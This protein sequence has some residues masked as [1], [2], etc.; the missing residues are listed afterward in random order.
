M[1]C[2]NRGVGVV[3]GGVQDWSAK[4]KSER[5][6]D[7]LGKKG[8]ASMHGAGSR[9][10]TGLG[11]LATKNCASGESVRA[12]RRNTQWVGGAGWQTIGCRREWGVLGWSGTEKKSQ[13]TKQ[14]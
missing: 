9:W 13:P 3:E 8:T 7:S 12:E 4:K 5:E 6:Q 11:F 2:T 1:R 10:R 14:K